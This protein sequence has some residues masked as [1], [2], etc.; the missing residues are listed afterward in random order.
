MVNR[1][2]NVSCVIAV[3]FSLAKVAFQ[4]IYNSALA[5]ATWGVV[6][7]IVLI[8]AGVALVC[9]RGFRPVKHAWDSVKSH[10]ISFCSCGLHP[11]RNWNKEFTRW[12][13]LHKAVSFEVRIA[14]Q[15]P[16]QP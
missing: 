7:G 13:K 4:A 12:R 16:R 2:K 11:R 1:V 3:L 9:F 14:H 10:L 6:V 5:I 15:P 8:G